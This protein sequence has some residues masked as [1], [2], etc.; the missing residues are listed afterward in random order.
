MQVFTTCA[1]LL[2]LND[3]AQNL[4]IVS[5]ISFELIDPVLKHFGYR[6]L[7]ILF[8]FRL[9][10]TVDMEPLDFVDLRFL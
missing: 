10:Q 5:A 8:F 6:H 9:L 2:Q 1:V 4:V 3:L 7:G